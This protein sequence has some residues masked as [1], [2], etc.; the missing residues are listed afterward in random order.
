MKTTLLY[1]KTFFRW[2]RIA[3]LLI[4]LTKPDFGDSNLA[5]THTHT[6]VFCVHVTSCVPDFLS[7]TYGLLNI[8]LFSF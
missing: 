5:N 6:H 8:F 4:Q 1:V 3:R 7:L 2:S